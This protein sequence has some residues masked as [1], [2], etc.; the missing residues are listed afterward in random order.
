MA[1]RQRFQLP[2][3]NKVLAVAPEKI[4][5]FVQGTLHE[6]DP[7]LPWVGLEPKAKPTSGINLRLNELPDCIAALCSEARGSKSTASNQAH[8]DSG[9]GS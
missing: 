8:V 6:G 2:K 5:A 1:E 9:P 3:E 4:A 7:E